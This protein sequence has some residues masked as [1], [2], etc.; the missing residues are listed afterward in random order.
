MYFPLLINIQHING[1]NF[2][3]SKEKEETKRTKVR[4][5]GQCFMVDD[6]HLN[7]VVCQIIKII[8]CLNYKK[9]I[10]ECNREIIFLS[11]VRKNV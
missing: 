8:E 10:Y 6:C 1:P 4:M 11:N 2:P 7:A 3:C 5:V 9:M